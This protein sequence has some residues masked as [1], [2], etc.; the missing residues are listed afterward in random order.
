MALGL[1]KAIEGDNKRNPRVLEFPENLLPL[2]P[3]CF[4]RAKE[5]IH[6]NEIKHD[7]ISR[8]NNAA[9]KQHFRYTIFSDDF[10]HI[11]PP[12]FWIVQ[13]SS[14]VCLSSLRNSYVLAE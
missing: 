5:Y 11:L 10:N 12:N 1:N 13:P 7:S 9:P 4:A 14:P 3:R 2:L 6:S 8:S